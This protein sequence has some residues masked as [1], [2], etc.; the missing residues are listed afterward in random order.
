MD[1]MTRDDQDGR[2]ESTTGGRTWRLVEPSAAWLA[3]RAADEA[4]VPDPVDPI[5]TLQA[6]VDDLTA[7]VEALQG[8]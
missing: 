7:T 4:D 8:A 2:W 6:Q 3:A 5:E 1:P